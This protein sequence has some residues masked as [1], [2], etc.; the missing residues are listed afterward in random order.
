MLF[1]LTYGEAILIGFIFALVYGSGHLPKLA[2]S[3][4]G[5]GG[6]SDPLE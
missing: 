6:A 2:T 1:G 4:G 3:L 5:K